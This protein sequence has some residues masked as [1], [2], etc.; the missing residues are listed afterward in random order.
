VVQRAA[1]DAFRGRAI[2]VLGTVSML[3]MTV[4]GPTLGWLAD[5]LGPRASLEYGATLVLFG[6]ATV[7]TLHLASSVAVRAR[8]LEM[9]RV[10]VGRTVVDA[11]V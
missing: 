1:G 9:W 11:A 4:G 5:H 8:V 10:R 7:V 3:G 2:A 6:T